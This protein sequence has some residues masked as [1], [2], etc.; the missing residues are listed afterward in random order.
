MKTITNDKLL[1]KS[2]ISLDLESNPLVSIACEMLYGFCLNIFK[3]I[4]KHID[5]LY[6][7]NDE[8]LYYFKFE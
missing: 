1:K 7:Y 8:S 2:S 6:D 4:I 3:N 5:S